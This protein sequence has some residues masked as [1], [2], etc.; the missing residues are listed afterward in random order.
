MEQHNT[1]IQ[2]ARKISWLDELNTHPH[3]WSWTDYE[4]VWLTAGCSLLHRKAQ[5]MSKPA[6]IK[7]PDIGQHHNKGS[8]K[9]LAGNL[10]E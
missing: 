10:G 4:V 8:W 1:L 3:A 9:L 5:S 7:L 6:R 2:F